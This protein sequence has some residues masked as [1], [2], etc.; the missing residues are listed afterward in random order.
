[1]SA[2]LY[3]LFCNLQ[4]RSCVVVGGNEMAETKIQGL[5]GAG[6]EIRVIAPEIT[7]QIAAW[8]Q[9]GRL[10]WQAS[11]YQSG[12]LRD[13]FL[14]VSV[15]DAATNSKVFEEAET[16][17]IFCNS[18]DDIEH[19]SCYASAVVRRG[20]LQIA[21]STSGQSPALAQRLRKELEQRFGAEYG[22]WV[23]NLGEL[24]GLLLKDKEIDSPRRREILHEQASASSF[25]AFRNS[26]NQEKT[27]QSSAE[28]SDG[29]VKS[30]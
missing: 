6:A 16:R 13:A 8:R 19:C 25:E 17:R 5:L 7:P 4:G 30:R 12:D 18:V 1:M 3:P 27:G 29:C 9:A 20:A 24:R 14:V 2:P 11:P 22:L 28:N 10:Q 15:S 26:L 21:I 23:K